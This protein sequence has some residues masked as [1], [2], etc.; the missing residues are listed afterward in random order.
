M[1]IQLFYID[2]I[3][4][5]QRQPVLETPIA[6]GSDFN[7]MPAILNDRRVSRIALNHIQ[8]AAYHTL[9]DDLEDGQLRVFDQ[10]TGLQVNGI[11]QSVALIQ[12]GDRLQI[13]P[14]EVQVS[15]PETAEPTA[16]V[17]TNASPD[18]PGCNRSIGFLFPRRCGRTDPTGCPHC[19]GGRV[20]D[21]YAA[22][23]ER[24]LYQGYGYYGGNAWSGGYLES[25][26]TIDFTE[27]DAASFDN[28]DLDFEQDM[29]AS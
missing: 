7:A 6:L 22:Y 24:S 20:A 27:A 10:G 15:L 18:L 5:T 12:A 8:I 21:P 4:S 1:R 14:C 23:P 29:G 25:G 13:G 2:P 28:S 17:A 26:G 16:P 19:E 11:A 9:L 3:T